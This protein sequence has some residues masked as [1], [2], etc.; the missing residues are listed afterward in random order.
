MREINVEPNH[1]FF[2]F[3]LQIGLNKYTI[4]PFVPKAVRRVKRLL[5]KLTATSIN[6]TLPK[7]Q[8]SAGEFRRRHTFNGFGG[9]QKVF[10]VPFSSQ[11]RA[12]EN[13]SA[14]IGS[15]I[16]GT[17]EYASRPNDAPSIVR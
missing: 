4:A 12:G 9:R 5:R 13:R 8:K 2:F 10:P 16:T 14:P 11:G 1:F 17:K 3:D 15:R 6:I 7:W